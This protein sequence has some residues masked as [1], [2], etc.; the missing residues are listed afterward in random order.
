MR[1]MQL[2]RAAPQSTSCWRSASL[3]SIAALMIVAAT[4]IFQVNVEIRWRPKD[5]LLPENSGHARAG[6]AMIPRS[7]EDPEFPTDM[8]YEDRIAGINQSMA[9]WPTSF[10]G[11]W[12]EALA[13]TP[14]ALPSAGVDASRSSN[15]IIDWVRPAPTKRV[16]VAFSGFFR[17]NEP[18]NTR[19]VTERTLLSYIKHLVL[20]NPTYDVDLY[21]HLYVQEGP[22]K[23]LDMEAVQLIYRT[24]NVMGLVV[25]EYNA[26]VVAELH[27]DFDTKKFSSYLPGYRYPADEPRWVKPTTR[28]FT[29]GPHNCVAAYADGFFSQLRKVQL[30]HGL[31]QDHARRYNVNYD[32]VIR[33]R[34]DRFLGMDLVL[35]DLP[36]DKISSPRNEGYVRDPFFSAPH[37]IEDMFAVGPMSLMDRY[38]SVHDHLDE[39]FDESMRLWQDRAA[40]RADTTGIA[41]PLFCPEWLVAR[42]I[43]PQQ[44]NEIEYPVRCWESAHQYAEKEM[45]QWATT[46]QPKQLQ[47]KKYTCSHSTHAGHK[48]SAPTQQETWTP[49]CSAAQSPT[50]TAPWPGPYGGTW[51]GVLQYTPTRTCTHIHYHMPADHPLH[52]R[53][54]GNIVSWARPEVARRAAVVFSGFLSSADVGDVRLG[55]APLQT[56]LQSYLKHLVLPNPDYHI[57][58]F[59]H[60]YVQDGATRAADI[61]G[62]D[63]I[64]TLPNVMG[65]TV[66]VFDAAMVAEI[67]SQ[68]EVTSIREQVKGFQGFFAEL[69]KVSLGQAM[70]RRHCATNHVTYNHVIRARLDRF[71]AAD[72]DLD[73]LPADKLTVPR[74][75]QVNTHRFGSAEWLDDAFAVGPMTLMD[76]YAR[77]YE[78][79]SLGADAADGTEWLCFGSILARILRCDLSKPR[80]KRSRM[81]DRLNPIF[82]LILT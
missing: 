78:A 11:G 9:P 29:E 74:S 81:S 40:W 13:F 23:A 37:W 18:G 24:P 76:Q 27:R 36:R 75:V 25:E 34:V 50:A 42:M 59:F 72:L 63:I 73:S 62:L 39:L 15:R 17:N 55:A 1:D 21:F 22:T 57:D 44:R 6:K 69:R 64:H 53:G 35:D 16:A 31:V 71:L 77:S 68:T 12:P 38:T 32:F 30:A 4:T 28:H 19:V 65:L 49:L 61:A 70:V 52:I 58:Y 14:T 45:R 80:E 8:L 67:H 47:G 43:P 82:A 79:A 46:L 3:L 51:P 5:K 7:C 54:K 33:A 41:N 56:T 10:S 48:I 26:D 2:G 60:V 66:E 20:P